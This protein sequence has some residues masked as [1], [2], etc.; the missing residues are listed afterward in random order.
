MAIRIRCVQCDKKLS[1][2]E[3]LVGK[4]IRCPQCKQVMKVPGSRA[5]AS[6]KPAAGS[7]EHQRPG[8][9]VT[10]STKATRD[11][12]IAERKRAQAP[13]GKGPARLSRN[14][15]Q[16]ADRD[17]E[18]DRPIRKS[19]GPAADDF[20]DDDGAND[21]QEPQSLNGQEKRSRSA[22]PWIGAGLGIAVLIG[23]SGWLALIYWPVPEQTKQE[24]SSPPASNSDSLV[25]ENESLSVSAGTDGWVK[26]IK[27]AFKGADPK[28]P[29]LTVVPDGDKGLKITATKD[30]E[31]GDYQVSV[32]GAIGPDVVLKV[33]VLPPPP[34]PPPLQK[35]PPIPPAPIPEPLVLES[36]SLLVS[37][38]TVSWVKVKK[39][40]FKSADPKTPFLTV[41][42][43]G[44]KGLRII[45]S[46][47]ALSDDYKVSVKGEIGP[48]VI[49]LVKVPPPPT[50]ANALSMEE[51]RENKVFLTEGKEETKLVKVAEGWATKVYVEDPKTRKEISVEGLTVTVA[52]D[53]IRVDTKSGGAGYKEGDVLMVDGTK[54]QLKVTSVDEIGAVKE[55]RLEKADN[56]SPP[57]ARNINLTVSEGSG[58]GAA[59]NLTN[60][61]KIQ[62]T[63]KI[64]VGNYRIIVVGT[65]GAPSSHFTI[66]VVAAPKTGAA[67]HNEIIPI[68]YFTLIFH[69][70]FFFS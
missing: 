9:N 48:D 45:A 64:K 30:A 56:Y 67:P 21:P 51:I 3:D 33:K 22:M 15:K 38:G 17:D 34:S 16:R 65:F 52:N 66:V 40:V 2:A 12:G 57:P 60:A 39:G 27:G 42:P 29:F 70:Y 19:L 49:L 6:E 25:L 68:T 46:K 37:A 54:A 24:P 1:V 18:D 36:T 7:R 35:D 14:D 10:R 63:E 11:E 31:P 47:D 55:A 69:S 23:A 32:K 53:P 44:D 8:M 5:E 62:T 50:P 59:F 13:V 28:T 43:D 61:V 26:V 58:K 20:E 4:S 41:V